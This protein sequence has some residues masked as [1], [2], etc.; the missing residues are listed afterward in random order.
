[1]RVFFKKEATVLSNKIVQSGMPRILIAALGN[2]G[3][4]YKKHRH[5]AG[6][7][8]LREIMKTSFL[9]NIEIEHKCIIEALNSFSEMN[10]SGEKLIVLTRKT[11]Y[12]LLI[13]LVDDLE[14][15]LGKIKQ[16]YPTMGHKGQN[17]I[18]D[19]IKHCGNE[20][21]TI[22]IGIGRP[23]GSTPVTEFVLSDFSNSEMCHI[24]SAVDATKGSIQ[25]IILD[26]I[27]SQN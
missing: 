27:K 18:R 22:R 6:S 8:V 26:V 3:E 4:L 17:G 24:L 5:N 20:F 25:Q 9:T 19:I 2:P 13:V 16:V 23:P 14:T 11:R 10:T 12:D 1:M 21:C 7:I 15:V